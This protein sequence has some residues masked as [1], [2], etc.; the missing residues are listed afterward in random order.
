VAAPENCRSRRPT[1]APRIH[2]ARRPNYVATAAIAVVDALH[3]ARR[4][5]GP[6]KGSDAEANKSRAPFRCGSLLVLARRD[7]GRH[8]ET[9]RLAR[10]CGAAHRDREEGRSGPG[11]VSG[12]RPWK[13]PLALCDP[14]EVPLDMALSVAIGCECLADIAQVRAEPGVFGQL[15][16]D[17]TVSRLITLPI[18]ARPAHG[19]QSTPPWSQCGRAPAP[20]RHRCP[21]PR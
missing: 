20:G 8:R 15:A 10:R 3:G 21:R 1:S 14:G 12:F 6:P 17:P 16:S 5:T 2:R 18:D 13:R 7:R 19:R 11:R 9:G 4:A